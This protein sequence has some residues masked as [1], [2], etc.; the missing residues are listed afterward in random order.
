[1]I[2]SN[3]CCVPLPFDAPITAFIA[4]DPS[5]YL[6]SRQERPFSPTSI[7]PRD[8]ELITGNADFKALP[9]SQLMH[10]SRLGIT[11]TN[12]SIVSPNPTTKPC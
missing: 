3:S 11:A 6:V 9:S 12:R 10:T 5:I 4:T 1:M 7:T 2:Q 8:E